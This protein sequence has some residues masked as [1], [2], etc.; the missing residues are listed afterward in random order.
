M[1]FH[2]I[3]WTSAGSSHG[4]YL[5]ALYLHCPDKK[6]ISSTRMFYVYLVKI[7]DDEF[8]VEH[9]DECSHSNID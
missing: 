5:H 8:Y 6:V 3:I 7:S 9:L 1:E 4:K 2:T